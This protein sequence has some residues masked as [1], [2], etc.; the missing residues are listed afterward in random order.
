MLTNELKVITVFVSQRT[1]F[2]NEKITML[3][4]KYKMSFT[5]SSLRCRE[6]AIIA[7][8]FLR[9]SDWNAVRNE[10]LSQNILQLNT[11]SSQKRIF[12]EIKS[13]LKHLSSP[14][15]QIL[16]TNVSNDGEV[17]LWLAICRCYTFIGEFARDVVHEKYI[18]FQKT[19]DICD[20]DL[21][22]E[23]KSILHPELNDLTAATQGKLRQVVFKLLRESNIIGRSNEILATYFSPAI[24]QLLT[25]DDFGYFPTSRYGASQ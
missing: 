6:S 19:V 10:V 13:R 21:F 20:Y 15:L 11:A 18:S 2:E 5:S 23:K 3:V 25:T 8:L 22:F 9:L 17:I 14:E 7:D 12:S 24:S 16:A 4:Q 1:V